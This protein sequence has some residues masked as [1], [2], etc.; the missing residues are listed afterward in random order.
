MTS[1]IGLFLP[2]TTFR[3]LALIG[4]SEGHEFSL[5]GQDGLEETV[6]LEKVL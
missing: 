5:P 3:G 6:L 2:I 4:L 1:P